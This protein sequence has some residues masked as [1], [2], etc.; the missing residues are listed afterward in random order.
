[1]FNEIK[2]SKS[3]DKNIFLA[4]KYFEYQK[5]K[6]KSTWWQI[7]KILK[8]NPRTVYQW[9]KQTPKL[10]KTASQIPKEKLPK[11]IKWLNLTMEGQWKF[12]NFIKVPIKIK[13]YRDI[14]FVL[15]QLESLDN[16]SVS[17]W[18]DK[19]GV[20]TKYQALG[21]IIG[22][23]ISDA[24][25]DRRS[26]L[27]YRIRMGLSKAYNWSINMGEALCYCL[28]IIGIEAKRVKDGKPDKKSPN[29]RYVWRSQNSSFIVWLKK[30]C[31]GLNQKETTTNTQVRMSWVFNSP[32]EMIIWILNGVYDGDGC[33][34]IRGWQITNADQPN[35]EFVNDL[36]NIFDIKSVSRGPK[37]VIE[38]KGSLIVAAKLPIFRFA[39]GKLEDSKKLIKLMENSNSISKRMDYDK[40]MKRIVN[41]NKEG[42]HPKDIPIKIFEEFNIGIHPRRVY[43]VLNRRD[44]FG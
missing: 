13:N 33:A 26:I 8:L 14:K 44:L 2:K 35:Q 27:S 10:I 30:S 15:D 17:K 22:L 41:L 16:N 37:S 19:Y 4:E 42:S 5:L 36:L 24:D 20:I 7:S 9:K 21:Y 29:G 39:T 31:L 1:M 11:N 6:R 23:M 34:Y 28:S 43:T 38:T 12:K 40:I 3:F 18:K 25:K 32:K